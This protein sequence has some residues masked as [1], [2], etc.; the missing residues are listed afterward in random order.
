MKK[1]IIISILAITSFWSC[2][3]R[4]NSK[5]VGGE[6]E[7][8]SADSLLREERALKVAMSELGIEGE[9]ITLNS[10]LQHGI[11]I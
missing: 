3:Q 2:G 10:Y 7:F 1:S 4:S 8:A 6:V 9:I 5:S 11:K